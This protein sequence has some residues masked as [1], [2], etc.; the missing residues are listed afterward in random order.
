MALHFGKKK[1]EIII[2][3]VYELCKIGSY[4]YLQ[5]LNFGT[6]FCCF[7]NRITA[8]TT[9]K[10]ICEWDMNN[11]HSVRRKR[12]LLSVVEHPVDRTGPTPDEEEDRD[13]GKTNRKGTVLDVEEQ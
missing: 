3:K 9:K 1:K 5:N 7:P 6:G 8:S 11:G 4:Y 13:Q 2:F 10:R 12:Q